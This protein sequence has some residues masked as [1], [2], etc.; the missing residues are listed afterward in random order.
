VTTRQLIQRIV[1]I[2]LTLTACCG[3]VVLLVAAIGKKNHER[4]KEYVITIEGKQTNLF[5]GENDI[6]RLLDTACGNQIKDKL[7]TEFNLRKLEDRLKANAWVQDAD[8][9][10]DNKDVLHVSVKER[11]PIARVFTTGQRSFYIDSVAERMPL[12][13][14]MSARV[15]AFTNF[16][17]KKFLTAKD[18]A[19]LY[20]IQKTA[21]FILKDPFWMAQV[22]QID[23]TQ[24]RNFEMVPTLGNHVVRLGN[25]DDIE[26]KFRRLMI[27]Y[28]QVLVRAGLDKYK[29]IDVRFDG[30]VTGTKEKISKVDSLQ[31]RKNVE[32][33]L[34][35]ARKMQRD[36]SFAMPSRE[37]VQ[38]PVVKG[39][40]PHSGLLH[41]DKTASPMKTTASKPGLIN[42]DREAE[43]PNAVMPKTSNN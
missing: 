25:G 26:A 6:A 27:F 41:G 36:T 40:D 29:I 39:S 32:K 38:Q 13:A 15:P 9:Y 3:L 43:T 16:P 20:D 42:E 2:A 17:D 12:S 23:I 7:L 10:F 18:S 11:E 30:Q 14:I 8:L 31:L 19:L 28:Q 37:S 33:L 5:I 21:S 1:F 24:D 34:E 22:Q 4:C 35:E